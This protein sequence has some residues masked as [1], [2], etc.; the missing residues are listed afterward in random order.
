MEGPDHGSLLRGRVEVDDHIHRRVVALRLL[1]P[2]QR[3][4]QVLEAACERPVV[5]REAHDPDEARCGVQVG[6]GHAARD[7][8]PEYALAR[9]PAAVVVRFRHAGNGDSLAADTGAVGKHLKDPAICE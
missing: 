9:S 2:A 1:Q 8:R 3:S 5:G 4:I 7:E 6:H